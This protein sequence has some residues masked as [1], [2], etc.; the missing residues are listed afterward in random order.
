MEPLPSPPR[1]PMWKSPSTTRIADFSTPQPST[2]HSHT[3][4][5]FSENHKKKISR[6]R[7]KWTPPRTPPDYW[8]IGFPTTQ[9]AE[10]IN[11]RA[12]EMH[13]EKRRRIE[14]EAE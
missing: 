11:R 3:K 7:Y 9:E 13:E 10:D 2:S 8:N 6:H 4:R 12:E 1:P 5:N 14:A